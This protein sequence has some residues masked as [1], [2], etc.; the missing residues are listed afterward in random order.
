M[1]IIQNCKQT[2]IQLI[3]KTNRMKTY[4]IDQVDIIKHKRISKKVDKY[5]HTRKMV[6]MKRYYKIYLKVD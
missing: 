2:I 5:I 1:N 4:K 6:R 3:I